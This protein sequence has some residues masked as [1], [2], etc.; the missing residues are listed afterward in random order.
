[1]QHPSFVVQESFLVWYVIFASFCMVLNSFQRPFVD[2]IFYRYISHVFL[3]ITSFLDKRPW[4][5]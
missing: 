3:E 1:L 4:Q 5:T 2:E